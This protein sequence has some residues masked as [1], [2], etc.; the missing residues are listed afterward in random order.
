MSALDREMIDA[1]LVPTDDFIMN[2]A[3]LWKARN[4]PEIIASEG[5][6]GYLGVQSARRLKT[7]TNNG[8]VDLYQSTKRIHPEKSLHKQT[9]DCCH[10]S[11]KGFDKGQTEEIGDV[12]A[13]QQ[14][15]VNDR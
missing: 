11:C 1:I 3:G 15:T 2:P 4:S 7:V 6:I 9:A 8:F 14:Q 10:I 5:I 13:K 12:P